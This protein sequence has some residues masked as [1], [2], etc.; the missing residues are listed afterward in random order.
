MSTVA[1]TSSGTKFTVKTKVLAMNILVVLIMIVMS[2][3]AIISL[4][5]IDT[6]YSALLARQKSNL[7]Y[8]LNIQYYATH[9]VSLLR[10][11]FLL[12]KSGDMPKI[13][14]DNQ[15]IQSLAKDA[16]SL[17]KDQNA[18]S[19]LQT[20]LS[21]QK[22]FYS[23]VQQIATMPNNKPTL[24]LALKE[25]VLENGVNIVNE[26]K[27]TISIENANMHSA[28]LAQHEIA[29]KTIGF[30]IGAAVI[31]AMISVL[32]GLYL[33]NMIARPLRQVAEVV[34]RVAHGD[35][36]ELSDVK[37][38]DEVG[39]VAQSVNDMVLQLREIVSGVLSAAENVSATSQEIAAAT[40][41][42]ASGS[43]A[44][45]ESADTV[46]QVFKELSAAIN[47][48]AK[49]AEEAAEL[50]SRTVNVAS[51]GEAIVQDSVSGMNKVREQMARLNED[52][53]RVGEIVEVIDDIAEQTNLLAL[54][55]AIEAARAG[56][57]G[58]GFAVVADEVRKLAE[59]SGEATKQITTIIKTMQANT[60]ASVQAVQ[61][62]VASTQK[63]GEA[64]NEIVSMVN[65][66]AG[67][68]TEIAAAG[69]EQSAQASEVLVSVETIAAAAQES[70]ASSEETASSTQSLAQLAEQL[71]RY[72]SVFK[73]N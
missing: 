51:N 68:V 50:S 7:S 16:L 38:R 40:E 34:G 11:Y 45:A 46:N 57:Q 27:K 48:V 55:A 28:A 72:V 8:T 64:F 58:R 23:Q 65:S 69:E 36:R 33:S 42:I 13:Q 19:S 18:T 66:S 71:N 24:Q 37:T 49:N 32:M 9:E 31:A 61:A 1:S 70:A 56:D 29:V 2:A 3:Y 14:S 54:N 43:T 39:Q 62:G 53:N 15:H 25:N 17:T 41:Q 44:Q 4:N 5:D 67:K 35:L 63:S 59:R 22:S 12:N 10:E 6:Q 26:M 47:S 30:L 52:S 73:V 60:Q 20:A 21:E